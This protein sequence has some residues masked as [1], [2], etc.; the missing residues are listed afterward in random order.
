MKCKPI[1][2]ATVLSL[3]SS[4]LIGLIV[5]GSGGWTV[6]TSLMVDPTTMILTFGVIFASR[7]VT[8]SFKIP[9]CKGQAIHRY[10]FSSTNTASKPKLQISGL[11]YWQVQTLNTLHEAI[12]SHKF[13]LILSLAVCDKNEGN[14]WLHGRCGL[15][16]KKIKCL[17]KLNCIHYSVWIT[18][19]I[20]WWI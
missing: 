19:P 7:R 8:S 12:L 3:P 10:Y 17:L 9:I 15:L 20:K 5:L 1:H 16:I 14:G 4:T 2:Q 13:I 6:I 18:Q 11:V